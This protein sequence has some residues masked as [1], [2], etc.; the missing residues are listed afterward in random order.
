MR[1]GR[2]KV[3]DVYRYFS[4]YFSHFAPTIVFEKRTA[5][6]SVAAEG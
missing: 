2:A 3:A 5:D 6:R 4:Y 1:S